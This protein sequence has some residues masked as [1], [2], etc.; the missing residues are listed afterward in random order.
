MGRKNFTWKASALQN[1]YNTRTF[2]HR[3]Q[4]K[5][6]E[7]WIVCSVGEIDEPGVWTWV[8]LIYINFI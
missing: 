7:T 5:R 6:K 2:C 3:Q 4:R 1:D 8:I